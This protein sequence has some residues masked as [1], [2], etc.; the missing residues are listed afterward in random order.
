[1]RVGGSAPAVSAA[2]RVWELPRTAPMPAQRNTPAS[3]ATAAKRHP[4]LTTLI[5][6]LRHCQTCRKILPSRL[7][8]LTGTQIAWRRPHNRRSSSRALAFRRQRAPRAFAATE[9]RSRR[10]VRSPGSKQTLDGTIAA[11]PSSR[12]SQGR[13]SR[14]LPRPYRSL[15]TRGWGTRLTSLRHNRLALRVAV[16]ALVAIPLLGG[17]WMW[18]RKSS[19]VAVRHIHIVGVHGAEAIEIRTALDVAAGRM[20]TMDFK[21]AALAAVARYPIVGAVTATTSFPHTVSILCPR[22]PPGRRAPGRG[23]THRRG[24]R[25]D[26]AEGAGA[27]VEDSLPVVNGAVEPAPGTRLR[28]ATPLAAVTVLGAAPEAL[29]RFVTRVYEGPEGLTVAMSNGLLVY[30]GDATR[31]HAKWLSLARVLVSPTAAGAWYVDVR[32]PERPAAGPYPRHRRPR[33]VHPWKW[34]LPTPPRRRSPRALQVRWKGIRPQ[35]WAPLRRAAP[36]NTKPP[37]TPPKGRPRR[38]AKRPRAKEAAPLQ[39]PRAKRPQPR[40]PAVEIPSSYT[41]ALPLL[42]ANSQPVVEGWPFCNDCCESEGW[43]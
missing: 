25:R 23:G 24:G 19:L 31:P 13:L 41:G 8:G 33:A 3:I 34:A 11:P 2:R 10:G 36:K 27:P 42:T 39:P 30:F 4:R 28:E 43:R 5:P 21:V 16:C 26:S 35:P 18:L 6:H 32:L 12:A 15:A 7:D 14:T 38:A 1:M 9:P 29:A 40:F 20:T 17:S 22:A 37:R